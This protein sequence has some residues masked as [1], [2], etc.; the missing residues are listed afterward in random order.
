MSGIPRHFSP[1]HKETL[2]GKG[3]DVDEPVK[4]HKNLKVSERHSCFCDFWTP[5]HDKVKELFSPRH[6][7][8][9]KTP[10][11]KGNDIDEPVKLYKNLKVLQRYSCLCDFWMTTH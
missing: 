6:V 8:E 4:P 1:R 9:D 7:N 5:A 10:C 11:G 2:C 3:N